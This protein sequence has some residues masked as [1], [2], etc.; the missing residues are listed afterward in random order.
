MLTTPNPTLKTEGAL[1]KLVDFGLASNVNEAEGIVGTPQYF[2]PEIASAAIKV[3]KEEISE[4]SYLDQN[5]KSSDVYS[6]GVTFF[7]LLSVS[8]PYSLDDEGPRLYQMI[9]KQNY[10]IPGSVQTHYRQMIPLLQSMLGFQANRYSIDDVLNF[11][12]TLLSG[13]RPGNSQVRVSSTNGRAPEPASNVM[14]PTL[15]NEIV[16]EGANNGMQVV[17]PSGCL[18]CFA[19][20]LRRKPTKV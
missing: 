11:I 3:Y 2:S 12:E 18:G 1:L 9:A 19:W 8:L 6:L 14:G 17:E 16:P 13:E 20:K 4:E 7:A 10:Q 5:C 15:I